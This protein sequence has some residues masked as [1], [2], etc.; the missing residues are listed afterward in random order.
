MQYI[1]PLC[2]S[3]SSILLRYGRARSRQEVLKLVGEL[4]AKRWKITPAK[5]GPAGCR[6]SKHGEFR[7]YELV[8]SYEYIQAFGP[9]G[10][11]S[12]HAALHPPP[13]NARWQVPLAM[14][15]LLDLLG[16]LTPIADIGLGVLG[17]VIIGTGNAA[18]TYGTVDLA[19]ISTI[20]GFFS[21]VAGGV[22]L[23][24]ALRKWFGVV[25]CMSIVQTVL[26]SAMLGVAVV[27]QIWALDDKAPIA[28]AVD[29]N[30]DKGL[31]QQIALQGQVI[32]GYCNEWSNARPTCK[33][34]YADVDAAVQTWGNGDE[35]RSSTPP[36]ECPNSGTGLTTIVVAENC[37]LAYACG[38]DDRACQTCDVDCRYQFEQDMYDTIAGSAIMAIT[39][40]SF[41]AVMIFWG[42]YADS[43]QKAS[44]L[45]TE[46]LESDS[47]SADTKNKLEKA[48]VEEHEITWQ[49]KLSFFFHFLLF[50]AAW[51][52]AGAGLLT[53]LRCTVA[54]VCSHFLTI[55]Q[56]R[57]TQIRNFSLALLCTLQ[58]VPRL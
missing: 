52:V 29:S 56:W 39:L 10:C 25:F 17:V 43:I 4:L 7:R 1:P 48:R 11:R 23:L 16:K 55:S 28:D 37:T 50:V 42:W 33:R 18:E 53:F 30:W 20:V 13:L 38:L 57:D 8:G 45:A 47:H 14:S 15:A 40:W 22:G 12:K 46:Q 26:S 27:T 34:W 31:R 24:A 6:T 2:S 41:G 49:S 58:F 36:T 32:P 9:A 44:D 5:F 51:A 21:M 35:P 54:T 19:T 3:S